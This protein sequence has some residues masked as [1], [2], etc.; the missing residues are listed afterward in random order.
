MARP[1]RADSTGQGERSWGRKCMDVKNPGSWT[2]RRRAPQGKAK[3][4]RLCLHGT[5]RPGLDLA[6]DSESAMLSRH[7]RIVVSFFKAPGALM[8][9][10]CDERTI[11]SNR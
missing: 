2:R 1:V 6:F 9:Y 7:G 3:R 11:W 4:G 5:F 10:F 8:R